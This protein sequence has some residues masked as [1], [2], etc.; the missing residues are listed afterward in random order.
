MEKTYAGHTMMRMQSA[1]TRYL[2]C[3][4]IIILHGEVTLHV[5]PLLLIFV[6]NNSRVPKTKFNSQLYL[7]MLGTGYY[8]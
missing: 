6:F 5:L 2:F 4:V 1:S 8:C 3:M 7:Y